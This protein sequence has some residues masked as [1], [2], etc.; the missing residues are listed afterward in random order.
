MTPLL[1]YLPLINGLLYRCDSVTFSTARLVVS[2]AWTMYCLFWLISPASHLQCENS[3]AIF[4]A[5]EQVRRRHLVLNNLEIVWLSRQRVLYAVLSLLAAFSCLPSLKREQQRLPPMPTQ[6]D[7]AISL[8][9]YL[10]QGDMLA[11]YLPRDL[12]VG[13]LR[14]GCV[15]MPMVAALSCFPS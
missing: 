9:L 14:R 6:K 15:S 1:R 7:S 13:W 2:T 12:I 11:V 8:S 5:H 3:S 10:N 4:L